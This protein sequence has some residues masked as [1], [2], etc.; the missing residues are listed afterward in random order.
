MQKRYY[1]FLAAGVTVAA[2]YRMY[3]KERGK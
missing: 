2:V 3:Q 1:L